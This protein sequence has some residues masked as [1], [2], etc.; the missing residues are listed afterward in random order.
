MAKDTREMSYTLVFSIIGVMIALGTMSLA[1][2]QLKRSRRTR[3]V[4]DLA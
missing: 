1:Y 3:Y 4:Y 2:V